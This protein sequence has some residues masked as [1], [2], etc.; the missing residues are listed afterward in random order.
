LLDLKRS[1]NVSEA[2]RLIELRRR[3]QSE[4]L[5]AESRS[6]IE[7]TSEVGRKGSEHGE[8]GFSASRD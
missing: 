1:V 7:L 4:Q 2:K 3:M 5:F 8:A 6:D